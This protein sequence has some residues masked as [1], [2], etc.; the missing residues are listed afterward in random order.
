MFRSLFVFMIIM[1]AIGGTSL[2]E[3]VST[4]S[5]D[6]VPIQILNRWGDK[7][8]TT[9]SA[10]GFPSDI[11]DFNTFIAAVTEHL[12]AKLAQEKLCLNSAESKARSLIQFSHLYL[13][14]SE[15]D[16]RLS[17]VRPLDAQ[18][19]GV[20]RI[21][22]PW[23]DI[24]IEREPV[25]SVRAIV[26]FNERQFL[27]DQAV[28]SGMRNVPPGIAI[29]LTN[30]EERN[31]YIHE[32]MHRYAWQYKH[33]PPL[34]QQLI[35]EL[36]PPDFLW[37]LDHIV[38]DNLPVLSNMGMLGVISEG[39]EGYTKIVVALIDRCFDSDEV[40]IKFSSVL[41]VAD[42]VPLEQYKSKRP[43]QNR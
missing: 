4:C 24:A 11:P 8:V 40:D 17:A 41:D 33:A 16:H 43:M 30:K 39:A 9:L 31:Q 20:C 18:F 15:N 27:A 29:P 3:N 42:L 6:T 5:V 10:I 7:P 28:L 38:V 26:R 25:P 23:I 36:V 14:T 19:V 34:G 32:Y 13:G 21:S 37:L 22:S 35:E 1:M 12:A 2:A